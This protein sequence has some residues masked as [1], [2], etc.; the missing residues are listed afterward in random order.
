MVA[1][2]EETDYQIRKAGMKA[3][4]MG[5]AESIIRKQE[6]MGRANEMSPS[7]S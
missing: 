1:P 5:I 3:V 7:P 2:T 6:F 4:M